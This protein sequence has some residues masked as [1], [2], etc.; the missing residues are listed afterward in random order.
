MFSISLVSAFYYGYLLIAIFSLK[1]IFKAKYIPAPILHEKQ[2]FVYTY[3]FVYKN[4][5]V[6]DT[7]VDHIG[8][9]TP[10]S[11]AY[12]AVN[13]WI[14]SYYFITIYIRQYEI[15]RL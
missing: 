3:L 4:F 11:I 10:P 15:M 5:M 1:H 9:L 7:K 8:R 14:G 6:P 12:P 2:S 13:T